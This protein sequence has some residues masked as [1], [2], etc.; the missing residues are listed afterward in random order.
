MIM[1]SYMKVNLIM[2]V[3]RESDARSILITQNTKGSS[4]K[5]GN[6]GKADLNG[7]MAKLMMDNG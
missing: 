3:R 2:I 7:Q 6:A 5:V 4:K 1:E